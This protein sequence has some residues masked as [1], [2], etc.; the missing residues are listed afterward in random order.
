VRS[1]EAAEAEQALAAAGCVIEHRFRHCLI[2]LIADDDIRADPA[3]SSRL[4]DLELLLY[5]RE[6]YW[7]TTRFWQLAARR[8]A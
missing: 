8:P 2:D 7:R 4:H 5:E 6:P 3:F 1:V